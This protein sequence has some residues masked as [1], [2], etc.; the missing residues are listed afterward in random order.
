MDVALMKFLKDNLRYPP[1]AG[2]HSI[3]GI[4][5][6]SF[7]V[8]ESG[9]IDNIKILNSPGFD[10]DHE[11]I[12]LIKLMSGK[13]SSAIVNGVAVKKSTTLSA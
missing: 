12:R 3:Q 13:W 6:C 1:F 8:S 10:L 7:E 9:I 11:A 2:E 5:T 4:V